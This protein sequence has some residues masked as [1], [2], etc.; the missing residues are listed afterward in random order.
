MMI[1]FTY[2]YRL[3]AT[4]THVCWIEYLKRQKLVHHFKFKKV[5]QFSYDFF[6]IHASPKTPNK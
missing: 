5:Q 2:Y 1:I 6:T 4:P 3:I